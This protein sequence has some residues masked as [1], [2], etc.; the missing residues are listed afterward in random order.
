MFGSF[1]NETAVNETLAQLLVLMEQLDERIGPMLAEDGKAFNSRWVIHKDADEQRSG[2]KIKRWCS[3][4]MECR[5][6]VSKWCDSSLTYS[7]ISVKH[8]R[9]Q[10]VL[11]IIHIFNV[12]V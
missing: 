3:T 2:S 8:L 6:V 10:S 5:D 4:E 7:D 1:D 11:C 9:M 12:A